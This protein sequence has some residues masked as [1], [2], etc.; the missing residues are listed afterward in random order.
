MTRG[1][2]HLSFDLVKKEKLTRFFLQ[3]PVLIKF[4]Q[5][6][7][8]ETIQ[9]AFSVLEILEIRAWLLQAYLSLGLF[10]RDCKIRMASRN[11]LRS[12][13]RE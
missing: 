5:Y 3:V 6:S 1:A 9:W 8:G 10:S 12:N 11:N 2:R 7:K 4:K 13:L